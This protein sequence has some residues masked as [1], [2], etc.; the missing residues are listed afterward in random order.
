MIDE[1]ERNI[2][3]VQI[4]RWGKVEK[5]DGTIP[6]LVVDEDLVPVEPIRRFLLDFVARGNRPWSVRSY[7]YD[8]LRW[9]RWLRVYEIDWERATSAES[10]DLVL[11]MMRADKPRNAARTKSRTTVGTVNVITRKR[12]LDDRYC[13]RTIRHSNAV[14]RAF[15][16]FW[17]ERGEGPL[18]NPMPVAR[19]AARVNAHHNPLEPFRPGGRLRYNPKLPVQRP[20]SIPDDRWL[21]LFGALRSNR[22]RAL[23]ALAVSNGARAAEILGISLEDIDW[24]D[25]LIRVTRKGT[26]VDQWL[27][28]SPEAFVW[29]RLHLADLGT[30]LDVNGSLWLTLRRRS[31]SSAALEYRPLTYDALRKV[32]TRANDVL[33]TN[34]TMHD[35]RHTAAIRMAHDGTLTSR[36]IQTILGHAHL[37]TTTEIYLVEDQDDTIRR[38]QHHLAH[39]AER[40]ISNPPTVAAGYDSADLNVL[41]GAVES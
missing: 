18:V 3:Q 17:I 14:V 40:M 28:A 7:A 11:W 5:S 30:S 39:R 6:W 33:G 10:R 25:Q 2:E 21:E 36:D 31:D 32:L 1:A 37:S 12:Y 22:D 23:L 27:P 15:Y 34:W 8:L 9:W 13:A 4:P 41:F 26:R 29:L 20:R 16:E 24:G 19:G 38:V 35:L